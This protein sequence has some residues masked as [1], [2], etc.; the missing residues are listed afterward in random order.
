V[1]I[2]F[3]PEKDAINRR[4]HGVSLAD[5]AQLDFATAAYEADR[6]YDDREERFQA[7]GLIAGRLHVGCSPCARQDAVDLTA[8]SQEA[9]GKTL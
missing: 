2:E 1:E 3:D 7:H 6:R 8:K 5:A 9:R 4:K